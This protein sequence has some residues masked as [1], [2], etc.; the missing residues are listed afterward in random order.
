MRSTAHSRAPDSEVSIYLWLLVVFSCCICGIMLTASAWQGYAE[1][2]ARGQP[3]A[4]VLSPD[5][6]RMVLA[7]AGVLAVATLAGVVN[8]FRKKRNKP[9]RLS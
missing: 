7:A 5:Q 6:Y 2:A 8:I 4:P 3:S 9:G 1:A